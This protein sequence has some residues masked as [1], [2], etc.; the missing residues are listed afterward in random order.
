MEYLI[1]LLVCVAVAG[2]LIVRGRNKRNPQ[3]TYVC[4]VCGET[5][6]ICHKAEQK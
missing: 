4:D 5:E 2:L 6:C 1:L 3:D